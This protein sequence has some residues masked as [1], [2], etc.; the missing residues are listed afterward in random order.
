MQLRSARQL[1]GSPW[2]LAICLLFL[3][4]I[5]P[6]HTALHFR[7]EEFLYGGTD[8]TSSPIPFLV[9]TMLGA[10]QYLTLVALFVTHHSA[11]AAYKARSAAAELYMT[12]SRL[13]QELTESRLAM[14]Q[15]QLQPHFLFNT[16][17]SVSA[18]VTSN[19][20]AARRM[21]VD[22]S[23]LLR[24][25]LDSYE[26]PLV[27]VERE[28]EMVRAY[29]A[30]QQVRFG[31]RLR[32]DI[33]VDANSRECAVPPMLLQPLVEN[34]VHHAMTSDES[35]VHVT[36]RTRVDGDRLVIEVENS[37]PAPD[38]D[39]MREGVGLGNT[40]QRL[41]QLFGDD[42]GFSLVTRHGGDGAIARIELPVRAAPMGSARST[43]HLGIA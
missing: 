23:A 38:H 19:P 32:S 41:Q 24:M 26:H 4:V 18:L 3:P 21:L 16:L 37:G 30:I 9:L 13:Q 39:A 1:L 7:M 43:T 8:A 29:L 28:L 40:R 12:Q 36:V 5:A 31:D 22:L 17:N 25:V 15:A 27:S 20:A 6:V 33:A 34:A 11:R 35:S 10:L 42:Y 2:L 14:L